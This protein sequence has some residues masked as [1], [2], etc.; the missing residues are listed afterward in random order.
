V[1]KVNLKTSEQVSAVI[2]KRLKPFASRVKTIMYDN[3][4]KFAGHKAIDQ[5]LGS[6]AYFADPIASWKRG[7]YKTTTAY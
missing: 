1:A 6:T 2:I 5:S 3:G 4:K 7:S